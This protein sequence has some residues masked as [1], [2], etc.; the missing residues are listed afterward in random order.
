MLRPNL[1]RRRFLETAAGVTVA[2]AFAQAT[3]DRGFVPSLF[4]QAAPAKPAPPQQKISP[5]NIGGGGRVERDF[6]GEWLRRSG[7]PRI[8]GYAITDAATEELKPWPEIGGRGLYCHFS[9]NVH[10][11]AVIMEIPPGKALNPGKHMYEQLIYVLSGRGYT[12]IE[13]GNKYNN[14]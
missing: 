14:V 7:V 5:A 2:S 3:A 12:R 13:Q 11:D 4:A 1:S 6:Y 10:M 8:E 9:G